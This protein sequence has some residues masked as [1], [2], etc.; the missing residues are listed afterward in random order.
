[1]YKIL[2]LPTATYVKCHNHLDFSDP[3][4]D[5]ISFHVFRDNNT[6]FFKDFDGLIKICWEFSQQY[7][8]INIIPKHLFEIVEVS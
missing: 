3:K 5:S 7:K 2:H 8:H 1:M 4:L 6:R